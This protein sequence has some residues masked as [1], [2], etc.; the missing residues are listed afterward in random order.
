MDAIHLGKV[1]N[2]KFIPKFA[3]HYLATLQN[4]E[5]QDVECLVRKKKKPRS[6]AEN[7]YYWG[8][9]IALVSD[10]TGYT[11]EEAHEAMKFLFLK[12]RRRLPG[13]L[14]GSLDS[15]RSTAELTTVEFEDYLSKIRQWASMELQVY[16]PLPNEVEY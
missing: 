8:V 16:I 2:N 3:D 1:I 7:R 5:G 14:T 10:G 6:I 11:D 15:V 9:V 12:Q 4:L 13:K